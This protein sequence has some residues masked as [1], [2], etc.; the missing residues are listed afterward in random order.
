MKRLPG[1]YRWITALVLCS[2]LLQ[3]SMGVTAPGAPPA[4]ATASPPPQSL[5]PSDRFAQPLTASGVMTLTDTTRADFEAGTRTNLDTTAISGTVRLTWRPLPV[6]NAG[7]DQTIVENSSVTLNGSASFSSLGEPLTYAWT[8]LQGTPVTLFQTGTASSTFV[9][10]NLTRAAV[11]RRTGVV[12][13]CQ[14]ACIP[15]IMPCGIF[16]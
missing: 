10:P 11:N 6:A 14:S 4:V 15:V 12:V 1:A 8:Q 16:G 3:P 9:A 2:L 13:P 7:P 5:P